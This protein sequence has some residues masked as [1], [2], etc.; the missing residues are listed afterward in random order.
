[1]RLLITGRMC[2]YL[3]IM[4]NKTGLRVILAMLLIVSI[5]SL[6]LFNT[7]L[8]KG[9]V[10]AT[11]V[12]ENVA[13]HP[14]FYMLEVP[15]YGQVNYLAQSSSDIAPGEQIRGQIVKDLFNDYFFLYNGCRILLSESASSME[16]LVFSRAPY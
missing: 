7:V 12:Q 15:E 11:I 14:A 16:N 13:G 9:D 2:S 1:M 4:D 5:S 6:I 3:D 8:V 10:T